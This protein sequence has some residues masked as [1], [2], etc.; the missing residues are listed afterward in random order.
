VVRKNKKRKKFKI[1]NL[2]IWQKVKKLRNA[3][4]LILPSFLI[5]F[6]LLICPIIYAFY[7]SLHKIMPVAR[8]YKYV[9]FTNYLNLF[10][11]PEWWHS[12]KATI[13]YTFVSVGC[14]ILLGLAIA[15]LF[16]CQFKGRPLARSL[17]LIPWAMPNIV[18]GI[19]WNW[20]YNP[21]CGVLN[22]FLLKIGI[23]S[24]Y[25]S[26]LSTP[27]SALNMIIISDVWKSTPL[28]IILI[29]ASLQ[30][31][32]KTYYEAAA[33]AGANAWQSFYQITLPLLKPIILLTLIIRTMWAFK[34]FDIIYVITK[35]GPGNA[36]TVFS[37]Y[38]FR[39]TFE[40]MRFGVGATLSFA[41]SII[42]MVVALFY[43]KA[44][45]SKVEYE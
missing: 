37:Y 41:L 7:L 43:I 19:L 29:L 21:T 30:V 12:L 24:K 4:L 38:I 35:G 11:N 28:V 25:R 16:N 42:I 2:I 34:V 31:I 39:E 10:S 17:L 3:Y 26:W 9:G 27:F 36:T 22:A 6:V 15:L 23:I 13:Y 5:I 44:L 32:P 8:I 1:V 33:I 45:G 14:E 18:N 20:I 40:N